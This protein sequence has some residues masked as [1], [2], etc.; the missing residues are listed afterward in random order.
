M[1]VLL[2][3]PP[4]AN[5]CSLN[6]FGL[7]INTGSEQPENMEGLRDLVAEICLQAN[8]IVCL[9]VCVCVVGGFV[10]KIFAWELL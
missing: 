5:A 9:L 6:L 10:V 7:L 1:D 3:Q 4:V 2:S 8:I